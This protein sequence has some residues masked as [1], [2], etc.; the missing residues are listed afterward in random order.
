M[1]GKLEAELFLDKVVTILYQEKNNEPDFTRGRLV[2]VTDFAVII[3]N[4]T[5]RRTL[6]ALDAIQ[7]I[8]E[9]E[10]Q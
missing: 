4:K 5:G 3:E 6:I 10:N 7:K 8:R 2:K 9:A 1:I